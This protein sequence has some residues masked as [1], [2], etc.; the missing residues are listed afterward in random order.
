MVS[1]KSSVPHPHRFIIAFNPDSAV[2]TERGADL[3]QRRH[4]SVQSQS[5]LG[6]GLPPPCARV[7]THRRTDTC[8]LLRGRK[9]L[10]SP[11]KVCFS[12][13]TSHS[14]AESG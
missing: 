11:R 14:I 8:C 6:V 5:L 13:M 1:A 10:S 3:E 7:I 9:A 4:R 12:L 2:K